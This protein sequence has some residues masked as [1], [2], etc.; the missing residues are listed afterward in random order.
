MNG[1][2]LMGSEFFR[3]TYKVIIWLMIAS[4]FLSLIPSVFVMIK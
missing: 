4:F 3:K 2:K 1:S